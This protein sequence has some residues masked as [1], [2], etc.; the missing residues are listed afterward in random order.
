M[1][2]PAIASHNVRSLAVAIETAREPGTR[3]AFEFQVLHGMGDRSRRPCATRPAGPRVRPVGELVAGMAYL[4]RRLLENTANDSFVRQTFVEGAAVEAG[5][6]RPSPPS[7]SGPQS[8]PAMAADRPRQAFRNEPH[9]E[10]RSRAGPRGLCRGAR[11]VRR[12]PVRTSPCSSADATSDCPRARVGEPGGPG[13]GGRHGR[14]RRPCRGRGGHRR[15]PAR[16]AGV[17]RRPPAERAAVLFRAAE[18]MRAA[19]WSSRRSASRR[20]AVARGRRRRRRGDRL[21]GVLRAG[22]AA[23]RHAEAPAATCPGE[24][25]L[26]FYRRAG[27]AWSSRRGTSRSPSPPAW[28]PPPWSPATPS[29]SSRPSRRPVIAA[30]WSALLEAGG[31]PPGRRALPARPGREVGAA[32]VEHPGVDAHRVHRVEGGRAADHRAAARHPAGP[33]SRQARH[34]RDGRQERDHRRRR[35]RPRRGGAGVVVVRLRL[36]RPEVLGVLAGDRARR[37]ARG[38]RPPSRRGH[39]QH[40]R[41]SGRGPRTRVPPVI[42]TRRGSASRVH[43]AG[44]EEGVLRRPSSRPGVARRRLLRRPP[45]IAGVART[46]R[47][48]GGDLRPRAR[49]HQGRGLRRGARHRQRREIRAHGRTLQP[50]PRTHRAGTPGVPRR[51]P[52]PQPRHHRRA[53]RRASPSAASR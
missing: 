47:S 2:R 50:Q 17:A 14:L 31:A 27:S 12:Q 45:V 11:A 43:R 13:R 44:H 35:R 28:R 6:S 16:P 30:H 29:S 1:C 10:L 21:P 9:A 36:R 48:P 8:P 53:R 18:L 20:Q 22:D 46:P 51:Q 25:N 41:R 33:A 5:R 37:R 15:R 7:T 19:R 38:V 42:T 23:P 3:D 39:P 34:R 52:L 26:Y 49:R 24:H 32:L 4:V 40:P